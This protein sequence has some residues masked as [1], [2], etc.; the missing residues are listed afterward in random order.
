MIR[1]LLVLKRTGQIVD[2]RPEGFLWKRGERDTSVFDII[3]MD[4]SEK[5]ER[6]LKRNIVEYSLQGGKIVHCRSGI[7]LTEELAVDPQ[8]FS[9][10][11]EELGEVLSR[12]LG[13]SLEGMDY[14]EVFLSLVPEEIMNRISGVHSSVGGRGEG[15]EEER[16]RE[17][18]SH[19][20]F[21]D[22]VQWLREKLWP[23]AMRIGNKK[24][25]WA[26]R[27]RGLPEV[28]WASQEV[29]DEERGRMLQSVSGEDLSIL[30]FLTRKVSKIRDGVQE[31]GLIGK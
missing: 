9:V 1:E 17:V 23:I 6:E 22:S 21:V 31:E 28:V 30:E 10:S 4:I 19:R 24:L 25:I 15:K 13:K 27:Y 18:L 20:A 7:E 12:K 5:V 14:R 8:D 3:K 16:R 29:S 11:E 2:V 26:A